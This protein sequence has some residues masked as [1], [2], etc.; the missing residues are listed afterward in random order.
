VKLEISALVLGVVVGAI[1]ALVNRPGIRGPG[2]T[3]DMSGNVSL[4]LED[5]SLR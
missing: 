2:A 3:T 5:R 4:G 1:F